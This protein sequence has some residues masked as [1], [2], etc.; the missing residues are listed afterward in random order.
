MM[1]ECNI[2]ILSCHFLYSKLPAYVS[3]NM[4]KNK[5][6]DYL[7]LYKQILIFLNNYFLR[8]YEIFSLS[9]NILYQKEIKL[10]S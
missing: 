4:L 5:G 8:I 1:S 9:K 3:K 2:L 7:S 6:L 10:L